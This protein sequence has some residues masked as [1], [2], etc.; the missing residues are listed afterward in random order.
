MDLQSCSQ[1]VSESIGLRTTRSFV[2]AKP[3]GWLGVKSL[4][5]GTQSL[6]VEE[7]QSKGQ[8]MGKVRKEASKAGKTPVRVT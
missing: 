1:Q 2:N 7:G 4:E 8:H 3:Q 6:H 5:K